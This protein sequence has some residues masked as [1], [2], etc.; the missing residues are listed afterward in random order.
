[1]TVP[2]ISTADTDVTRGSIV[3]AIWLYMAT[4]SVVVPGVA[5]K[6]VIVS[7]SKLWMNDS[8]Q[9]P[10]TPVRIIGSTTRRNAVKRLAPHDSAARSASRSSPIAEDSASRSAYGST[11]TTCAATSAQNEP[12]RCSSDRKRRNAMPSTTAGIIIGD[13]KKLVSAPR[14]GKR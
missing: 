13:R 6:I 10:A 8:T 11:I 2:T 3:C 4:G 5:T 1:M 9:P 7:S 12:L 14:P